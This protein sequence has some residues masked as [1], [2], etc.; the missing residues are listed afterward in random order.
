MHTPI[1]KW[2]LYFLLSGCIAV[3]IGCSRSQP[4]AP[5]PIPMPTLLTATR[6]N[7][8]T[9]TPANRTP[10]FPAETAAIVKTATVEILPATPAPTSTSAIPPTPELGKQLNL[11]GILETVFNGG[12]HYFLSDGK[13]GR[14]VLILN[15]DV[16]RAGGGLLAFDRKLIKIQGE[17]SK[18]NPITIRVTKIELAQ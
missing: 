8:T 2:V 17:V 10:T 18:Q 14:Y 1:T 16:T 12:A 15:E 5:S 6:S 7:V 13:G 9:H 4:L 11:I 3:S